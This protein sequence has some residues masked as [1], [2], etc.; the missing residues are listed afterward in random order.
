[1][2]EWIIKFIDLYGYYGVFILI[3]IEN[4]FPPIPS[5]IILTFS[6]FMTT[7][8][9]MTVLGVIALSTSGSITGAIVLYYIGKIIEIRSLESFIDRHGSFFR[10]TTENLH[11]AM[12]WFEKYGGRTIFFCRLIPIIRSLISIPAGVTGMPMTKF[13]VFTLLGTLLWNGLLILIGAQLG[14]SW[15]KISEYMQTYSFILISTAVIL[16]S[17]LLIVKMRSRFKAD[18]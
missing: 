16:T 11:Q 2:E 8:T 6:G 13:L 17:L 3:A 10:M 1:M 4:V 9:S 18:K 14:A 7:Q 15:W 12:T 5:E